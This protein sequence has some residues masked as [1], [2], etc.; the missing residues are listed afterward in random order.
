MTT[1]SYPCYV[2]AEN[3]DGKFRLTIPL[4]ADHV[5]LTV[6]GILIF[7]WALRE[8]E[9]YSALTAGRIP[10]GATITLF[11]LESREATDPYFVAYALAL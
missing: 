3:R 8:Y 4:H 1:Q 9:V 7:L 5:V 10:P 2:I 11:G 6:L